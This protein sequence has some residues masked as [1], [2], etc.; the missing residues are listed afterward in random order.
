MAVCLGEPGAGSLQP[1]CRPVDGVA[2]V[3]LVVKGCGSGEGLVGLHEGGQD[4]FQ[5]GLLGG[6]GGEAKL[7]IEAGCDR[8]G[9]LVAHPDTLRVVGLVGKRG[10]GGGLLEWC[11]CGTRQDHQHHVCLNSN[12]QLALVQRK[13]IHAVDARTVGM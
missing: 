10:C 12:C 13:S 5:F 9:R 1:A 11:L 6:G 4:G 3:N 7:L 2:E 8:G